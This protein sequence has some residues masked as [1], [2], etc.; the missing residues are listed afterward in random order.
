VKVNGK[1]IAVMG[2]IVM[3]CNDPADLPSGTVIATP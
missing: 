1:E 3:T 2:S